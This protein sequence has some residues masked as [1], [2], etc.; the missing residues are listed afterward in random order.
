MSNFSNIQPFSCKNETDLLTGALSKSALVAAVEEMTANNNAHAFIL[1]D[2]DGFKQLNNTLGHVAGN[3][4]LVDVVNFLRKGL[5]RNDII[6]RIGGDEFVVLLEGEDYK[7]R[8]SLI[9]EFERKME[10]N[11]SKGLVVIST[12]LD[13]YR[14]GRDIC[15]DSIFERADQRMY[16]RKKSLKSMNVKSA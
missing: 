3:Q 7:R 6:G 16:E 12:G 10:E 5:R 8:Q 9:E 2:L 14:P 11:N 1:L 13:I 15:F 4:L